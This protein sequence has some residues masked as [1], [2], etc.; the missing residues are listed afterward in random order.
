M[1]LHLSVT[2]CTHSTGMHS[3]LLK[4][5]RKSNVFL[6]V[7]VS[8]SVHEGGERKGV[9]IQEGGGLPRGDLHPERGGLPN[10]CTECYWNAV[11]FI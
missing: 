4:T 7:S 3:C 8:H 1:F 10:S 2:V 6:E 5:T 11:L 9:C